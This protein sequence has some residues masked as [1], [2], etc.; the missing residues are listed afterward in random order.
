V[1]GR[2]SRVVALPISKVLFPYTA[3]SEE[4]ESVY[5]TNVLCRNSLVV[6]AALVTVSTLL[7]KP[8]ILIL[9]GE[10][11][12]PGVQVFY[13][14]AAG[15]IV[16][17]CSNFLAV[18]ISAMGKSKVV[19]IL[20]LVTLLLAVMICYPVIRQWGAVGAGWS[21]TAIYAVQM[22]LRLVCYS[23]LAKTKIRQVILVQR[24]DAKYYRKLLRA[25]W[26][27]I[28]KMRKK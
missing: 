26:S 13:G 28:E 1:L 15:V 3:A 20:G 9:Y 4:R 17:P 21:I 6:M 5:R 14:L 16:W 18:H 7:I 23:R 27:R 11:F 10:D 22:I 25:P 8:I 2:Q 19:S 12:L 24:N